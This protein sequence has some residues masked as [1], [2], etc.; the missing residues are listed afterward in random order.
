MKEL[1]GAGKEARPTS[2]CLKA[3]VTDSD[4]AT[5]QDVK[6][7]SPDEVGC[8]E[9]KRPAQVVAPAVATAKRHLTILVGHAALVAD[10]NRWV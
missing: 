3:K 7:K 5:G 4:E 2:V 6:E 1:S 10:S 9:G 8:G